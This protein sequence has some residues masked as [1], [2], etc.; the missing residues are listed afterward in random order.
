MRKRIGI[1]GVG[2]GKEG[3][4]NYLLASNLDADRWLIRA[5]PIAPTSEHPDVETIVCPSG[6]KVPRFVESVDIVVFSGKPCFWNLLPECE[7]QKRATVCFTDAAELQSNE[8]LATLLLAR[9][10]IADQ[11]WEEINRIV[12]GA[13]L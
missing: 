1:V 11:P 6:A 10:I 7:N 8:I 5:D 4:F 2:T 9:S 3:E 13:M 12:R